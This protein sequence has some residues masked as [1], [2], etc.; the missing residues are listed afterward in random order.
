MQPAREHPRPLTLE[1]QVKTIDVLGRRLHRLHRRRFGTADDR[2]HG[3]QILSHA[4]APL[5]STDRLD[6]DSRRQLHDWVAAESTL[7][8]KF[9]AAP[10]STRQTS[11]IASI[12]GLRVRQT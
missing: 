6:A 5:R 11:G 3:Q 2:I 10:Q 4:G 12:A 8:E 1:L 9:R 7:S